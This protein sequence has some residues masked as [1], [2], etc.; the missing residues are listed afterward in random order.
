[1]RVLWFTNTPSCYCDKQVGYNGGGWIFSLEKELRKSVGNQM[2]LGICFYHRQQISLAKVVH[3]GVTYYPCP[4]P[5]KSFVYII[6]TI[7]GNLESASYEHEK[8]AIPQL[9]EVVNDFKPDIIH[10]FGSENIYGLLSNYVAIPLVLHIQGILTSIWNAYLPPFVSWTMYFCKQ[11]SI[12]ALLQSISDKIAWKRNCITEQRMFKSIKYF[13]GRTEWDKSI[14]YTLNPNVQY[15][16]CDEILRDSFYLEEPRREIPSH[17]FVFTT[18]ISSQLYKGFDIL[19][20]TAKVL[21]D[22]NLDFEW[23]VFGDVGLN[24]AKRLSKVTLEEVNVYIKGIAS[25]DVIMCAL[26]HSTA[27]IHTSYIDNSPNALC[28]AQVLGCTCISTNVGGISS[29]IE[30]GRTGFLVPVNDPYSMAHYIITVSRDSNLNS[31]I[32]MNARNEALKRHNKE[33]NTKC[34]M[35]IYHQI[36]DHKR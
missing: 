5:K 3:N 28:E 30:H 6:K 4:R 1:M 20:K 31:Q 15:F 9:L 33:K 25:S 2:E 16:H 27:Y 14:L 21:K 35:E 26:L 10:V 22:M 32:G 7:F 19:L 24:I 29:L 13:M 12:K 36:L 17:R 11:K 8:L 18:V 34:V 23:N